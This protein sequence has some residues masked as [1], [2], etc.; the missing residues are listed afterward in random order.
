MY[1]FIEGLFG[2]QFRR[3]K[4]TC[5]NIL[6]SVRLL[7]LAGFRLLDEFAD[8]LCDKIGEPYENEGVDQGF[9]PRSRD[10]L[11]GF[12]CW[13]SHGDICRVFGC[14]EGPSNHTAP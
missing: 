2:S 12:K 10:E 11:Q 6:Q 4:R 13:L 5:R 3:C 8:S 9:L 1:D 7:I 14:P